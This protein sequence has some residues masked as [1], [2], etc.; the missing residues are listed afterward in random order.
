MLTVDLGQ[1]LYEVS[2]DEN[3]S[4]AIRYRE[5]YL[6]QHSEVGLRIGHNKALTVFGDIIENEKWTADEWTWDRIF[7]PV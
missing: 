2:Y 4:E 5:W 1:Q 7:K 6:Y 3:L